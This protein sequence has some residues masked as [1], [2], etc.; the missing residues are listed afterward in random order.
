[1]PSTSKT[2]LVPTTMREDAISNRTR[3]L[4]KKAEASITWDHTPL[5]LFIR[6][7]GYLDNATLMILCLVCQQIKDLIWDG[8]G[9]DNKLIRIFEL[10]ALARKDNDVYSSERLQRFLAN[11]DRYSNDPTKNRMLQQYHDMK[12]VHGKEDH[13]FENEGFDYF[14]LDRDFDRILPNMSM[15][16]LVSL[17]VSSL[18]PV[19]HFPG[20]LLRAISRMV[21]NLRQ[22]DLSNVVVNPDTFAEFSEHC[23]HIEIM[24]WNWLS[25]NNVLSPTSRNTRQNANAYFLLDAMSN[26]KE[27]YLDDRVFYFHEDIDHHNDTTE[28]D[29]TNDGH[30][31]NN[32]IVNADEEEDDAEVEEYDAMADLNKY[33][34]I[35]FLNEGIRNKPL[36]KISIR[37]AQAFRNDGRTWRGEMDVISQDMLIKCVRNAPPTL[38]WFRSDLSEASIHLLQAE[39]PGIEFV[40]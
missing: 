2:V 1:M 39:R 12:I 33:P 30:A 8:H 18:V 40:Q 25:G 3:G 28:D 13:R 7:L 29:D 9:M 19:L 32:A 16:G 5:P 31:I 24:K 36:E 21:P 35:V 14:G 23:R 37:N 11:M 22:L 27:L 26:L 6:M 15:A 20:L 17:D 4:R 34:N 38:V 10:R